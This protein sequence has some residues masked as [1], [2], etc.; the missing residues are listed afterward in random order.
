MALADV[1]LTDRALISLANMENVKYGS[2][3]LV[4]TGLLA[5][6][7]CLRT[8]FHLQLVIAVISS[9]LILVV[10]RAAPLTSMLRTHTFTLIKHLAGL[11]VIKQQCLKDHSDSRRRHLRFRM[12]GNWRQAPPTPCTTH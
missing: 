7:Y 8:S 3:G 11:C 10:L 12:D 6:N 5:G 2:W 4:A 9:S 1:N